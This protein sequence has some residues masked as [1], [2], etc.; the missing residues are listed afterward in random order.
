MKTEKEEIQFILDN[1]GAKPVMGRIAIVDLPAQTMVSTASGLVMSSEVN[2]YPLG[3]VVGLSN[4]SQLISEGLKPGDVVSYHDGNR[5]EFFSA[6]TAK[7]VK[8]VSDHDVFAIIDSEYDENDRLQL[9]A[10]PKGIFDDRSGSQLHVDEMANH[11]HGDLKNE[12]ENL[13]R[14]SID[15]SPSIK[16][17]DIDLPW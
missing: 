12:I 13:Y 4:K 3:I 6:K 15:D 17:D 7:I 1:A 8:I 16:S 11:A 2:G 10:S 9:S 5:S 14:S